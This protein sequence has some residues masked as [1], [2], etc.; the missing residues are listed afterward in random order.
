MNAQNSKA[1]ARHMPRAIGRGRAAT[2]GDHDERAIAEYASLSPE[3]ERGD[4]QQRHGSG[5]REVGLRRIL[6]Q[7]PKFGGQRIE[8]GRQRQNCRRA[9]QGERLQECHQHAG[10]QGRQYQR[11]GDVPRGAPPIGTNDGG[12]VLK[13]RRHALKCVGKQGEDVRKR[14]AGGGEDDTR[15]G[16]DIEHMLVASKAKYLAGPDVQ[17]T[18]VW[19]GQNFPRDGAEKRRGDE[20]GGDRGTDRASQRHV[21]AGNQKRE[22][23]GDDRAQSG[24]T[25]GDHH[26]DAHGSA[27]RTVGDQREPVADRDLPLI[28]RHAVPKQPAGRHY[29]QKGETKRQQREDGCGEIEAAAAS[30]AGDLLA[31]QQQGG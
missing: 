5:G 1:G 4:Q 7:A 19:G 15:Y 18:G 10:E 28:V 25:D 31:R 21:C 22:R 2:S 8:T 27:Q 11:N 30:N 24:D 29:H 9:E 3:D 26:G 12:G 6:E 17:K 13:L 16:E 20:G 14:V 23:Q